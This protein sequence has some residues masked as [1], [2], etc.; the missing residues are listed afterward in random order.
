MWW[1]VPARLGKR[2]GLTLSVGRD[3]VTIRRHDEDTSAQAARNGIH[4]HRRNLS[5]K[6]RAWQGEGVRL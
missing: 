6:N 1:P 3:S 2:T 5:G 4:C